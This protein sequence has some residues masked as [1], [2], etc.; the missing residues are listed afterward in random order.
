MNFA[1]ANTRGAKRSMTSLS[2][3]SDRSTLLW[4]FSLSV[5]I[6][7]ICA[8]SKTTNGPPPEAVPA[9]VLKM[10][11]RGWAIADD[12]SGQV[13]YGH[14]WGNREAEYRGPRG[15]RIVF[16]GPGDVQFTWW[17]K[18]DDLQR[19]NL[20]KETLE[21][22]IMPG[23][24]R[25]SWE[26]RLAW[27]TP[28]RAELI[29]SSVTVKIYANESARWASQASEARFNVILKEASTRVRPL[30]LCEV[31]LSWSTW[32]AD[33]IRELAASASH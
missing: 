7:S 25:E 15:R 28:P 22:W 20:A 26:S 5:L 12:T 18:N 6:V 32:R 14:Y 13:P 31:P 3:M 23:A 16:M 1:P 2:T 10:A 21:V 9:I 27:H 11:P 8:C 33:L 17:D 29:F 30:G 4:S 24:Y 19:E